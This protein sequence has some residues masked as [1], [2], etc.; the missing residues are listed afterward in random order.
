MRPRLLLLAV[1]LSAPPAAAQTADCRK[2]AVLF[3]GV[4]R[5]SIVCNFPQSDGFLKS[6][7]FVEQRCSGLDRTKL[8]NAIRPGM[9]KFDREAKRIGTQSACANWGRFIQSLSF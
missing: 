3:G 2:G 4:L 9:L 8:Q 7:S 1:V 5:A 6:R